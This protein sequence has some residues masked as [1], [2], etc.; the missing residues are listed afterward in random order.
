MIPFFSLYTISVDD[1]LSLAAR[2]EELETIA[3]GVWLG[4]AIAVCFIA[5]FWR[6]LEML[7]SHLAGAN[8]LFAGTISLVVGWGLC[9]LAIWY[10]EDLLRRVSQPVS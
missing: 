9:I 2:R 1:E 10:H 8:Y 7:A 5:F 3:N 6:W 4:P